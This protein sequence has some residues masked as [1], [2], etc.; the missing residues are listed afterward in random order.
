MT[1]TLV[2]GCNRGIGLEL[3]R[4][5]SARG[6]DVIAVCRTPSDELQEVGVRIIDGIDVADGD[7]VRRLREAV[8]DDFP[9]AV[10]LNSADFQKRGFSKEESTQ[11]ARW[12]AERGL[13]LIEISGGVDFERA[14]D[15]CLHYLENGVLPD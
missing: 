5:L 15:L 8:G 3:C 6:D 9:V 12:L 2:T 13:D 11:V 7:A 10:K 1:T 4:Q 14:A